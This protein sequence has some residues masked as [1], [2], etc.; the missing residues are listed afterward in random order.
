M[1]QLEIA[2]QT[3]VQNLQV[4][5]TEL[6]IASG[7]V[8]SSSIAGYTQKYAKAETVVVGGLNAG[9]RI[10]SI[11][12]NVDREITKNLNQQTAVVETYGTLNTYLE[13]IQNLFGTPN[14]QSS[15]SANIAEIQTTLADLLGDPPNA[16]RQSSTV[17][18]V[19]KLTKNLNMLGSKIQSMRSDTETAIARGVGVINNNFKQL[20]TLNVQ[21]KT[22]Q[23]SGQPIGELLDKRDQLLHETAEYMDVKWYEKSGG[24]IML[25]T[26]ATS[27]TL[28]D[29]GYHT[30]AY[31]PKAVLTNSVSYTGNPATG[32]D[33]IRLGTKQDDITSEISNGKLAGLIQLRD[34]IL[35]NLH[36]QIDLLTDQ[37]MEEANRA[38]NSGSA[39]QGPQTLT[40]SHDVDA[41]K[42]TLLTADQRSVRLDPFG[43]GYGSLDLAITNSTGANPGAAVGTALSIDLD[44]LQA[45]MDT[46]H[47]ANGAAPGYVLTLQ[48]VMNAINGRYAGVITDPSA[49]IQPAG[50]TQPWPPVGPNDTLANPIPGLATA[51]GELAPY[52]DPDF[53]AGNFMRIFNNKLQISNANANYAIALNDI[54]TT[55]S[56]GTPARSTGLN[57]MFGLNDLFTLDAAATSSAQDIKLRSDIAAD[58]SKFS[59]GRLTDSPTGWAV[60]SGDGTNISALQ[61]V[62]TANY[63]FATAGGLGATTTDYGKYAANIIS[64]NAQIAEL[65][66][67]NLSLENGIKE[68]FKTQNNNKSGVNLDE[69]FANLITIQTSYVASTQVIQTVQKMYDHLLSTIR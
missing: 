54:N 46:L 57:Y 6:G 56:Y 3:A 17:L 51:S 4:R 29:G 36:E 18:A 66:A 2:N 12:R 59:R 65:N 41:T 48:D 1:G 39:V 33:G 53:P 45:D 19:D 13:Q 55:F 7:N 14:S 28:I 42:Y 15:V 43:G 16:V 32:I 49:T 62:Y 37:M 22:A 23:I 50:W 20:D 63:S 9:I 47:Q 21:I 52:A 24:D 26:T 35:P 40:G 30:L 31:V 64:N 27:Q 44:Q 25:M 34:T 61:G 38:Y 69:Q 10:Q 5:S 58:P 60:R 8:A 67:V 68:E 11:E